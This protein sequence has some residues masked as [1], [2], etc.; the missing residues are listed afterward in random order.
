[1]RTV[2]K[3]SLSLL[4]L[5]FSSS[6]FAQS[7][8]ICTTE[9]P[10]AVAFDSHGR[11]YTGRTDEATGDFQ[12][13]DL[14]PVNSNNLCQVYKAAAVMRR[15]CTKFLADAPPVSTL[16]I[17]ASGEPASCEIEQGVISNLSNEVTK[18]RRKL[19]QAKRRNSR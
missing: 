17:I 6:A 11:L 5:G 3:V 4:A 12:L 15:E 2:I 18:L 16:P 9:V 13:S 14:T 8:L 19:R 7:G 10:S 1:M